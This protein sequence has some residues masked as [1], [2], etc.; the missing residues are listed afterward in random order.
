[1]LLLLIHWLLLLRLLVLF[2][3]RFRWFL[4]VSTP[5]FPIQIETNLIQL[6]QLAL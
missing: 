5:E 2:R 6:G 4:A 3:A 1:M